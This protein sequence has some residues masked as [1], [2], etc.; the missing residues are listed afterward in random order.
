MLGGYIVKYLKP[1]VEI[2]EFDEVYTSEF[3]LDVASPDGTG[4]IGGDENITNPDEGFWD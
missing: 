2:L 1:E 3:G 4:N